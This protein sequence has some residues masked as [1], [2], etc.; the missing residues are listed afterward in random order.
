M[1]SVRA[2]HYSGTGTTN[3]FN[4]LKILPK[5]SQLERDAVLLK[6]AMKRIFGYTLEMSLNI[7]F[8]VFNCTSFFFLTETSSAL[9]H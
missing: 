7:K 5:S 6:R 8:L 4:L 9:I 3:T 2:F 1:A